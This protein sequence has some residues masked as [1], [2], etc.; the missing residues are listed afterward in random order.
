[1]NIRILGLAL[2]CA[3]V[4]ASCTDDNPV[5]NSDNKEEPQASALDPGPG[6]KEQ[7]LSVTRHG[8]Q[9]KQLLKSKVQAEHI[10]ATDALYYLLKDGGHTDVSLVH[11]IPRELY[12][13]VSA[14]YQAT[15]EKYP[16]LFAMNEGIAPD[17]ELTAD[18]MYDVEYLNSLFK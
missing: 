2:C 15:G 7:V 6:Y 11:V 16:E 18:Q 10:F 13:E 3:S 17:K 9:I 1:M 4:L 12:D 8:K 5:S 14:R